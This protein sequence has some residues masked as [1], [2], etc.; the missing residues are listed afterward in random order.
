M[1]E[2]ALYIYTLQY[3]NNTYTLSKYEQVKTA[4]VSSYC[5]LWI[6]FLAATTQNTKNINTLSKL[7]EDGIAIGSYV[8]GFV[9]DFFDLN[10]W[11]DNE[12]FFSL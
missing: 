4:L 8:F 10:F 9:Q 12:V 6:N 3:T 2:M 5:K 7:K 11:L 1:V